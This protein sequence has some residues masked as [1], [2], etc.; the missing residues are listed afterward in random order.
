MVAPVFGFASTVQPVFSFHVEAV[1]RHQCEPANSAPSPLHAISLKAKH[2]FSTLCNP[3]TMEVSEAAF[4]SLAASILRHP[5]N[6]AVPYHIRRFKAHFAVSPFIVSC[7]WNRMV[8]ENTLPQPETSSADPSPLDADVLEGLLFRGGVEPTLRHH[9]KDLPAVGVANAGVDQQLAD[10]KSTGGLVSLRR[11]RIAASRFDLTSSSLFFLPQIIWDNRYLG[12][13]GSIC[14]VS[15]DGTDFRI[16]EPQ[17]FSPEW[18]SHKFKGAGVRYE[19]AI[20][21]QTGDIVWVNG[22][23]PCGS[24][25]DRVIARDEG[26]E[27]ALDDGEMYVGDGGYRDGYVRAETPTG[28]NN[29]D[30]WMK[31]IARARHETVNARFKLFGAL[32]HVFRHRVG[33]ARRGHGR[34]REHLADR[35]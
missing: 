25:S 9:G 14:L 19:V 6:P 7:T 33:K 30:Q 21:L 23:F 27:D 5:C 3:P 35:H 29:Q 32:R 12:Y 22:P 31:G 15:V 18:Y 17:P 8:N 11:R 1:E 34:R 20:C 26:L 2:S 4:C 16:L 13:N 28:Y 24:Y 10:R